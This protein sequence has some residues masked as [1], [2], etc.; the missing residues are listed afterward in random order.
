MAQ[1]STVLRQWRSPYRCSE[2]LRHQVRAHIKH[3]NI[4]AVVSKIEG[5]TPTS[6]P[7]CITS[8]LTR[9]WVCHLQSLLALASSFILRSESRGTRDP[10]LLSQIR[11]FT[12]CRLLRLAGRR[13]RYSTPPPHGKT[14]RQKSKSELL[15]DWRFT[16]IQFV[17]ASSPLRPTT[18]DC[19]PQLNLCGI[20]PYVTSTLTRKWI[21]L[22]WICLAFRQVYISHI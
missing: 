9:G 1:N 11:D 20:S 3:S 4:N 8:A 5:S 14:F 7:L 19:F 17:L 12:F 10:I 2:F 16:A 21:C 13:R 15:Y 6:R 22:L 18:R